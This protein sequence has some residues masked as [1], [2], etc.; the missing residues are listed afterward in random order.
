[1]VHHGNTDDELIKGCLAGKRYFQTLL[2]QKYARSLF[3]VCLRYSRNTSEAED[4]L[5]ES[6]IKIYTSLKNYRGEGPLGAWLTRIVI[7]TALTRY[8][9]EKQMIT[10][11]LEEIPETAEEE[12]NEDFLSY[13]SKEHCNKI[14]QFIQELP[15]G[16][17]QVFNLYLFEGYNHKEIAQMLGISESTSRTQLHKAKLYLKDKIFMLF[18]PDK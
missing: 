2:Y 17:R 3:A 7:N 8:R 14:L 1:M 5:Q 12:P 15:Q 6:F 4:L 9:K 13:L 11:E 18:K 10:I 16:Y